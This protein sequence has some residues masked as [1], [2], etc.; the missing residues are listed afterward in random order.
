MSEINKLKKLYILSLMSFII[1]QTFIEYVFYGRFHIR[2]E[3]SMNIT[4]GFHAEV[5]QTLML[6]KTVCSFVG[7]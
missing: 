7:I 5:P 6:E 2:P 4:C 1:Q 3:A